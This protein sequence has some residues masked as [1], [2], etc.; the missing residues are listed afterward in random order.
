VTGALRRTAAHGVLRI[1]TL[2]VLACLRLGRHLGRRPRC[3]HSAPGCRVLLT[4]TFYSRNWIA[5]HLAPLA[6]A[7]GC[8]GVTVVSVGP[9]PALP[10]VVVRRPA[11][12][13][14]SLL[15][16]VPSR[17]LTFAWVALR[18]RPCIVGGFHLL[19]NGL[20][21]TLVARLAGARAVYFC[22]GGPAEVLDGGIHAENRLYGLMETPDPLVERLL[23]AA[24][25]EVDLVVAMGRGAARFFIE[26]GVRAPIRVIAGG[27][28]ARHF[29]A[30]TAPPTEDL[31]FVGRLSPIKRVDLFLEA[32]AKATAHLPR[33][34]AVVVG[35]GA[36]RGRLE[37]LAR[38]LGLAETVRFAGVQVE[39]GPW[40]AR[41]RALVLTSDSE[42][43]PLSVMEAMTAGVPVIAS[44]VG[45]LADL[46][47]DGVNGFLV[48]ERTPDAFA[49]RIVALLSSEPL[50]A[51]L[52]REASRA[53]RRYSLEAA[54]EEW[55]SILGS[56]SR[57]PALSGASVR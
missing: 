18:T 43:L 47:E 20:A 27:I 56:T 53:A 13:V 31:V 17:L 32:V 7:R 40:L 54:T 49:E 51:R 15:G 11:P 1:F 39:V 12:W 9:V 46:V 5:S 55:E 44:H 10:A 36:E 33:V 8:A 34:S 26:R 45:D 52:A 50:R 4:G 48:R 24:V 35:D 16:E 3:R 25:D 14:S 2:G 6:A 57:A 38:S 19:L 21:A 37:G 42:G 23:V 30:G 28:D 41:A 29:P 22:V